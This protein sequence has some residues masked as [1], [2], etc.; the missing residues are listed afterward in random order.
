MSAFLFG[1]PGKLKTLLDR[2]TATRAGYLDRIDATVSSRAPASTAL[3]S[4]VWTG[5]KAGYLDAA[6]TSRLGSIKAIYKGTIS[7]T[8]SGSSPTAGGGTATITAVVDAKTLIFNLG[9]N[10][11]Q[12]STPWCRVELTNTTT[13]TAYVKANST[14]GTFTVGYM[15]VEFN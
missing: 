15:V 13:V 3:D 8:T 1:V 12:N 11:G 6:V 4:S 2:L 14:A 9:V 5:T 7:V 10:D